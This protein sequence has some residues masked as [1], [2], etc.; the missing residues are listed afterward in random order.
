M[1]YTTEFAGTIVLNE[2]LTE[3]Q[4]AYLKE[5][6]QTR[7]MKRDPEKAAKL[8][9]PIREAVGLPIGKEGE[10]FVGGTGSFGQD[11]DPSVIKHNNPPTT[12]PGLWNNW[13]VD[14]NEDG[15]LDVIGW[16][17]AEKFYDYVE[18]MKY[19]IDNF[20]KPWG[21][22][23]NGEI[24]WRGEEWDDTGVIIIENNEVRTNE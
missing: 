11:D 10:Y 4:A 6:S 22:V 3:V 18:W 15:Q 21:Y 12:Q 8:P 1:G 23:A 19:I 20:L 14:P 13:I 7:R 17:G 24:E 16:N 2:P 9:D 5:F